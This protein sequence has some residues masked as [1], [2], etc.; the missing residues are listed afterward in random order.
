MNPS[1]RL[2]FAQSDIRRFFGAH[3]RERCGDPET[4]R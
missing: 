4:A 3:A 1:T 2:G